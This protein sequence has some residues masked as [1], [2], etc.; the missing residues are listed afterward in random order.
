[1]NS[2]RKISLR[3]LMVSFWL[4]LTV[5]FLFLPTFKS[6][7]AQERVLNVFA[8]VDMVDTDK[9]AEFEKA[10]DIRVNLN[11]YENFQELLAKLRITS[12]GELDL[13]MLTEYALDYLDVANELKVIDKSKLNFWQDIHPRFLDYSYDP[14]NKYTIPFYWDI[15]GIGVNKKYLANNSDLNYGWD[16]LFDKNKSVKPVVMINDAVESMSIAALYLYEKSKKLSEDQLH[17]I[18]DLLIEQKEWVESY[19]DLRADYYLMS[20]SASAVVSQSAYINRALKDDGNKFKFIIPKEGSFLVID[21]LVIPKSSTKE[22]DVYKFINFLFREDVVKVVMD[23]NSY[24]T[25]LKP[26]LETVDLSYLGKDILSE[27]SF[28]KLHFFGNLGSKNLI[29][30]LWIEI[31]AA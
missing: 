4:L 22:D 14:D 7:F 10:N 25:V 1:M 23:Q 16:L 21:S 29:N 13:I 18:K 17:R 31:R 3:T 12:S 11:Y 30:K 2:F 15:Y 9:I 28:K 6:Y 20:N 5:L 8:W 24:M 26:I 27:D 19:T